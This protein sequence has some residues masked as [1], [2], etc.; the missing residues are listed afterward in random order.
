MF[1]IVTILHVIA[2]FVLVSVILM[3]AG[4]GGGLS[5]MLG[6]GGNQAQKIFGTQTSSMLGKVTS[7]CAILFVITS[8]SLGVMTSSRGKSLMSGAEIEPFFNNQAAQTTGPE[9]AALDPS[10]VAKAADAARAEATAQTNNA[11]NQATE[12][13][14]QVQQ[15]VNQTAEAS[16]KTP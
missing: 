6:G 1:I 16:T 12:V 13:V 8:I 7:Y 3:Q 5:E 14:N 2:C 10:I 11:V 4:R 9:G 15:K